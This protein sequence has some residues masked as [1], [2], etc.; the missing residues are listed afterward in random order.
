MQTPAD[1]QRFVQLLRKSGIAVGVGSAIRFT[2]ALGILGA[3]GMPELYWAARSTLVVRHEHL[4]VFDELFAAF[5]LCSEGAESEQE[6]PGTPDSS[7]DSPA[8][9]MSQVGD[10][11][12]AGETAEQHHVAWSRAEQLAH[13]DLGDCSPQE[14]AELHSAIRALRLTPPRVTS[15]RRRSSRR[16]QVDLR[17]TIRS[18]MRSGSEVLVPRHRDR[19]MTRRRMVLLVDVSGSMEPYART[20]LRFAHAAVQSSHRVEVFGFATRLTRL[21]HQLR[22]SEPDAALRRATADT[23]DM[24]GGTRLGE[25]LAEFNREWGLRGVARGAVVVILS[26]GWDRGERGLV[27]SEMKRLARVAERVVWVNPLKATDGYEPIAGGMAE[28]L[29]HV[30]D[31]LEGHS[32][33]SLHELAALVAVSTQADDPTATLASR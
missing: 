22:V 12:T 28:A 26:D 33:A 2:E 20:L 21:T 10:S 8:E 18:S 11:E 25:V 23:A 3:P 29:R 13:R 15:R 31:F 1:P 17:R 4:E 27:D 32:L 19:S 5:F 24:S 30:D 16:G 6:P 7:E 14:L 9:A